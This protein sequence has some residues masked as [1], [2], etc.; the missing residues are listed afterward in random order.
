MAVA[1]GTG[2]WYKKGKGLVPVRL[3]FV[4]NLT[5]THRVESF[6]TTGIDLP[7][8]QIIESYTGRWAIEITFEGARE[9]S[10]WKQ[11]VDAASVIL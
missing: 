10:D 1:T 8:K 9:Q 6:S 3:V 4:E 5:G 11:C 7:S 2:H